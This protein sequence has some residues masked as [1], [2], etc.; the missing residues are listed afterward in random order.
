MGK[1]EDYEE[2]KRDIDWSIYWTTKKDVK[3]AGTC[4]DLI[5]LKNWWYE[6]ESKIDDS[7]Y[8]KGTSI[9]FTYK[10]NKY[11]LNWVFYSW[12]LIKECVKRLKKLGATNIQINFGELD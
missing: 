6:E 7:P 9:Y 12:N 10:E 5:D 3:Y 1:R 2:M 8:Y 11:Y 4:R